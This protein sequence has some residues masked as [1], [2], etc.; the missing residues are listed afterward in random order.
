MNLIS[1]RFRRSKG[2]TVL[3]FRHRLV[4]EDGRVSTEWGPWQIAYLMEDEQCR[5][6]QK[7]LPGLEGAGGRWDQIFVQGYWRQRRHPSRSSKRR[8]GLDG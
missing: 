8:R 7:E 3:E 5:H 2:R 4:G 6:T 1:I